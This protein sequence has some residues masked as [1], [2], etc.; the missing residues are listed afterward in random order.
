MKYNFD[1]YEMLEKIYEQVKHGKME[2][3]SISCEPHLQPRYLT[4]DLKETEKKDKLG[5]YEY[6]ITFRKYNLRDK[7]NE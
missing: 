7:E 5:Y 3:V 2:I 1:L 4:D 6:N